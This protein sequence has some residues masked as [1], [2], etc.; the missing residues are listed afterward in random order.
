MS[1]EAALYTFRPY[2][3]SDLNFINSSWGNSYYEGLNGHKQLD[4]EEFHSYHRPIRER[5]LAK[6]NV[7]AIVCAAA[8]DSS[9]ILGWILVEKPVAS[10]YMKLHFL[11]VKAALKGHGI[12]RELVKMALPTRPIIY[13]HSTAKARSIIRENWKANK[14]EFDRWFYCAHLI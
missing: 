11:Y 6:S 7:T 5:T 2:D 9:T 14:N 8:N 1:N 3:P 10:P 4:A 12:A 13:T